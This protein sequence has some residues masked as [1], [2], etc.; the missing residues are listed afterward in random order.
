MYC[1]VPST[2]AMPVIFWEIE[3]IFEMPKS[4]IFTRSAWPPVAGITKTFCG[5]MSRWTT[6]SRC[7]AVSAELS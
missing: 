1:G 2:A 5:C 6:P 3:A 4:R 7:A